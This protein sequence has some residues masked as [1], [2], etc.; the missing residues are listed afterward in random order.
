MT[1]KLVGLALTLSIICAS[2]EFVV[3][4]VSSASSTGSIAGILASFFLNLVLS[5]RENQFE[6]GQWSPK[7]FKC[8]PRPTD[9]TPPPITPECASIGGECIPFSDCPVKI[10]R[11]EKQ[12]PLTKVCCVWLN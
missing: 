5:N 1:A 10:R 4:S 12:C 7:R 8:P 3:Q 11:F 2:A 9:P 6:A